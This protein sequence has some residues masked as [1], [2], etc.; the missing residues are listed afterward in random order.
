MIHDDGDR[1]LGDVGADSVLVGVHTHLARQQNAP[2]VAH[3]DGLAEASDAKPEV[4]DERN[5]HG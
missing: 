5:R 2:T 3:F 1:L 4:A